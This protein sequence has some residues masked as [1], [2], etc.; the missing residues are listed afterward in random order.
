MELRFAAPDS[1]RLDELGADALVLPFFAEERPL[2]GPAGL[3]D[4]RL[5]GQ[6][7]KLRLR[8]R[9]TGAAFERVLVPGKPLTSFD[10][11]FLVGLGPEADMT[12]AHA[13]RACRVVL[14]MLDRCLVRSAALVLP[15]RSTGKLAAETALE[16]FLRASSGEHEQDTVTV[17]EDGDL[18]RALALT[19]ERERRKERAAAAGG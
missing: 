4:W 2:R 11:V 6:L 14:E 19:L 15:G 12:S 9:L 16:V 13:E 7:S 1:R 17:I 3:V 8:G 10:K 5:R 18:H